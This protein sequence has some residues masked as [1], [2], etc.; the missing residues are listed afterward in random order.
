MEALEG[1][2]IYPM[3]HRL[4]ICDTALLHIQSVKL[5]LNRHSSLYLLELGWS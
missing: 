5:S 4:E 2:V 3:S 1:Q